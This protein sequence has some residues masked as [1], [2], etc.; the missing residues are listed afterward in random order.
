MPLKLD[1]CVDPANPPESSVT[2]TFAMRDPAAEGIKV[3]VIVQ[4]LLAAKVE[5]HE[6]DAPKS[7][8]FAPVTAIPAIFSV[9]APEFVKV[10]T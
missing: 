9:A 4:E 7:V 8:W 10:N 3:T 2:T 6:V 5:V 1:V